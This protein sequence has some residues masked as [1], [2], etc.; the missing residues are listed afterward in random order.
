MDECDNDPCHN[1][2]ACSNNGGSYECACGTGYTGNG[3][4]CTGKIPLENSLYL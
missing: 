3:Y 4:N 1:N 2:A